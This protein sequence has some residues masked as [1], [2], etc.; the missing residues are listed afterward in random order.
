MQLVP[1]ITQTPFHCSVPFLVVKFA[2][3]MQIL[4][5]FLYAR[6]KPETTFWM[7][8]DQCLHFRG[9]NII[10]K[11]SDLW[12]P[13]LITRF[14]TSGFEL[15]KSKL[16]PL[17]LF[18]FLKN[19]SISNKTISEEVFHYSMAIC[20]PCQLCENLCTLIIPILP[21]LCPLFYHFK[22]PLIWKPP[23]SLKIK[24]S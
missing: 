24:I 5:I 18:Y 7:F 6:I 10:H 9:P 11:I 16:T 22:L 14:F 19:C 4:W 3:L 1:T 21:M 15:P 23:H 2:A 12:K 20:T 8:K 13:P 17:I